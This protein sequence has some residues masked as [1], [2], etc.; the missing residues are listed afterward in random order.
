[1]MATSPETID[2]DPVVPLL[3]VQERRKSSVGRLMNP[4]NKLTDK[5][6]RATK[7][8]PHTSNRCDA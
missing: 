7:A 6:P 2:N 5:R 3:N 4:G 1:M 8:I